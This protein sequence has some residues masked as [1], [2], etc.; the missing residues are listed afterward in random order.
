MSYV[1]GIRTAGSGMPLPH[2]AID[3]VAGKEKNDGEVVN[4]VVSQERVHGITSIDDR[5]VG[6]MSTVHDTANDPPCWRPTSDETDASLHLART[7]PAGDLEIAF[8]R[9]R[10]T[11]R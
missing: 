6:V 9:A 8:P 3:K 4:T 7:T 1:A 10:I 5:A 11:T 2:I